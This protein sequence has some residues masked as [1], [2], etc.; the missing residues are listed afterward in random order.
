MRILSITIA[1]VA[2]LP[3]LSGQSDWPVYGHDPGGMKYSPL[4]QIDR[5]NV[6]NLHRAWTYH[7]GEAGRPFET[8]PLVAG[9]RMYLSTQSGRI[10]ALAPETG[11]EIWSYDPK[12][13]RPREHR[14]VSYW[15]GGK[16]I[17]ARILFATGDS[18]LI[19]LDA[20]S[21]QRI[22]GFGNHGEV[23][24]RIGVADRFPNAAYAFTS[25]PAIYR[26][27]A[28][29][30]PSTPEGPS[31]GPSG[32]PRAFDVRTGKMVWR[33]H[34]VPQPGE[35]GNETWGVDGWKDR[36]GPSL[37]G[38]ITVDTGRGLVFLST[39]NP[40][41][42]FYGGDRKGTNLYANCVIALDAA[43]GKLRWYH[44]LIHHDIF[45]YDA[46]GGPALIE[47]VRNGRKIPAVAQITKMGLLFLLERLTGK[48]IFG[49]EE[50]PVPN[51]DVPG[52]EAWP[53]QPFP[54]K[55]PPLARTS[56][57]RDEVSRRTP[58]TERFCRELFGQL[59]VGPLYTPHGTEKTLV[60]PGSMGGG[61]WG[62][63]SFDPTLGYVFV[64]TSNLG[65]MGYMTSSPA[66]SPMAYRN[67]S[68]YARFTDQDHY[69]CQ[70]PPWGELSAVNANTGEI[71]WKVPLG[72]FE[73]LE[74]QGLK[75]T[76]T[77]NVG[78]T[79]ATAGGLVFVAATNDA[80]FRAFDS[81]TGK[82][83]WS[84][85]LDATGNATPISYLGRDGKQYVA[86][87]AGGPGHL[88]NVGD[89]SANSADSL[90][91]F[92]LGGRDESA[93][94]MPVTSAPTGAA[95][96]APAVNSDLPEAAGKPLVVRV[97]GKCHGVGTFVATRMSRQE[98]KDEVD[99]MVVRGA[100]ANLEEI[101]LIVEYLA[102]NLGGPTGSRRKGK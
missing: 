48:A 7:T 38:L 97:C 24:L 20:A 12:V 64:N 54:L 88:R 66:G 91:A 72:N 13:R 1:A 102:T 75:N 80:R 73:E 65:T 6:G 39:G 93:A 71:A 94:P 43:T 19:A 57:T 3:S 81:R 15:P 8:T 68:A 35:P 86:I 99:N 46:P 29:V 33:F 4:Q 67:E 31:R 58:E 32:D 55:P 16:G 10:V 100:V 85:R 59:R 2:V 84:A 26:D 18:R 61:N 49:E 82:E 21:G 76:G 41:D 25:P 30:G 89:M 92:A 27:L 23:D 45:D 17:P 52:E 36:S 34:T 11:V 79:I 22:E 28:I 42:S 14:G 63:V 101:G 40:A 50:R 70:Q 78:G 83:L 87:A 62:G 98:W 69:P 95:A 56:M 9:G 74:S 96:A 37:W 51:S 5:S 60:F 44:Q 77:P 53:T 90:I 47:V